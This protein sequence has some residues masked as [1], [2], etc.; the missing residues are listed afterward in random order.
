MKT[1]NLLIVEEDRQTLGLIQATLDEARTGYQICASTQDG[2]DAIRTNPTI[3]NVIVRMNASSIDGCELTRW[4]RTVRSAEQLPI[5]VIVGE[6]QLEF[7]GSAFDAGANDVLI[8]PFEARELR[9]RMNIHAGGPRHR[10]DTAHA[11]ENGKP[12]ATDAAA[13]NAQASVAYADD[14]VV[15]ERVSNFV[16]PTFD[17]VSMRFTYGASEEQVA[18]WKSDESVTKVALDQIMVCPYCSAVPTFRLGCG[19]CGSAWAKRESLV[20]HYACA[21]I[22][23]ESE[24]HQD[25]EIACPKCRQKGLI[26]GSDFEVVP[27]GFACSDCSS[28]TSEPQL[29]GHCL[30]CQHRF[31]AHE[32]AVMQLTGLHVHRIQEVKV[33]SSQRTA[34]R[35]SVRPKSMETVNS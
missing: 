20:H 25:G 9:M 24:F 30:S 32:A 8:D 19:C 12:E 23:A 27:G 14:G 6:D 1:K 17:S 11:L 7:A 3:T 31:P 29:I 5:L 13:E 21:H 26:A 22:G 16:V 2:W 35:Q 10:A 4:I 33:E 15:C 28:R 18:A 34:P